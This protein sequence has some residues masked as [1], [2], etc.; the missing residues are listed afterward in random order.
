[1]PTRIIE[2]DRD[3]INPTSNITPPTNKLDNTLEIAQKI[4]FDE[5]MSTVQIDIGTDKYDVIDNNKENKKKPGVFT[6]SLQFYPSSRQ[7]YKTFKDLLGDSIG[8]YFFD[9]QHCNFYEHA[10]KQLDLYF[11]AVA[12]E[13]RL[14]LFC[15]QGIQINRIIY[16]EFELVTC[17][18]RLNKDPEQIRF[19][20]MTPCYQKS[21]TEAADKTLARLF[22]KVCLHIYPDCLKK[23]KQIAKREKLSAFLKDLQCLECLLPKLAKNIDLIKADIEAR[24]E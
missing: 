22:E 12:Q 3:R 21:L 16:D 24:S 23:K 1:M 10:K 9:Q 5:D 18:S 13:T 8:N 19:Y 2:L 6:F 4:T 15:E 17:K 11:N 20:S 14:A 7:G